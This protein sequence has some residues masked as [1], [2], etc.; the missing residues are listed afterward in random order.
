MLDKVH[1]LKGAMPKEVVS[2]LLMQFTMMHDCMET[3]QGVDTFVDSTVG[4]NNFSWYGALP[5]ETSLEYFRPLFEKTIGKN[6]YPTY[7]YG[8]LYF[9]SSK[10]F[11]LMKKLKKI[12]D[13]AI[14]DANIALS[15]LSIFVFG[16]ES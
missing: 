16:P 8:S 6:L 13:M 4:D 15:T 1:Y 12:D 7:S 11:L 9:F 2:F 14:I 5:F 3:T 10:N